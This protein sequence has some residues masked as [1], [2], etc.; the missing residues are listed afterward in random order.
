[1]LSLDCHTHILPDLDDGAKDVD[2]SLEMLRR[3]VE[4]GVE[5]V[6]L[7]PH[8]YPSVE[9]VS[10][11]CKRREASFEQLKAAIGDM[12]VPQML[13]GAEVYLE[14]GVSKAPAFREL[15]IE[16]SDRL[17]LEMP[18]A[19]LC[20]WMVEEAENICFTHHCKLILAHLTRYMAYYTDEDFEQLI[21]LP[22]TII[23]IN[24]EDMLYA[25]ARKRVLSWM[26]RGFPVLFG[27]DCHNLFCRAPNLDTA[28]KQLTKEK[29]GISPAKSANDVAKKL[30]WI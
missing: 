16:G 3:T 19:P 8:Y 5:T 7:T 6:L 12:F 26:Q 11:F 23:Q 15:C 17:L 18:Y 10:S 9:D 1:M 25:P 21:T 24:A 20:D 13:L 2:T 4:Y 27:S 22:Q 30:G 29:R 28:A 14:R